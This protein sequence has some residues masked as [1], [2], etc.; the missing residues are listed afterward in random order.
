[1]ATLRWSL[2]VVCALATGCVAYEAK[3]IDTDASAA[4][5]LAGSLQAPVVRE[6]FAA[7]E[8]PWPQRQWSFADLWL[9]AL[10]CEHQ[11]AADRAEVEVAAAAV[12]QAGE[13]PN[14]RFGFAPEY[15]TNADPGVTPWVLGVS[16]A[17]PLELGGKRDARLQLARSEQAGAVLAAAGRAWAA[18]EALLDL[19]LLVGRGH[20][21]VL[22]AERQVEVLEALD[23]Q[24]EA[25]F[26]A[27]AVG[28]GDVLAAELVLDQA[29]ATL[30]RARA[31][32]ARERS[33][34]ALALGLPPTALADTEFA[35]SHRPDPVG[36]GL[37][38]LRRVALANRT[39]L[40]EAL[41]AHDAAEARLRLEVARQY[42]DLELGP[43]FQRDQNQD[44]IQLGVSFELP[45]WHRND[46]AIAVAAA[47]REAA[48]RRFEA[49]QAQALGEVELAYE[50]R[51]DADLILRVMR[52]M[53]ASRSAA[54]QQAQR[55]FD[56]GEEDAATL[57][58]AWLA[59]AEGR[60]QLLTADA[61][62]DAAAVALERAVGVPLVVIAGEHP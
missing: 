52:R 49:A 28:R 44:K 41:A 38:E 9:V 46:G 60:Q 22:V 42:P 2:L 27:G 19:V 53:V 58:Q 32:V 40:Q 11:L 14:P 7:H 30:L 23:A 54:A 47:A 5:F 1:M 51:Q 55:R 56:A 25:R 45:L 39:D 8:R 13:R 61:E 48:A 3:P 10:C 34:L 20:E 6:F 36:R 21:A 50:A 4:K 17:V 16:L 37:D 26:A 43:G 35:E 24:A 15:V 29:R 12:L 62:L 59:E 18:R 31:D 57:Q 33:R